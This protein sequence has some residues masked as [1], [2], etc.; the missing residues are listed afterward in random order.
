M[1]EVEDR[2]RRGDDLSSADQKQRYGDGVAEVQ[3]YRAAGTVGIERHGRA[4]IEQSEEHVE[5]CGG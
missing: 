5:Q 3:E 2:A 1:A 4:E